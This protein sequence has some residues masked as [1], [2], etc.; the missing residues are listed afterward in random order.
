MLVRQAPL[1]TKVAKWKVYSHRGICEKTHVHH[2]SER[3]AFDSR[4]ATKKK[5]VALGVS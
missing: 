3:M 2:S 4:Y 5:S 1:K